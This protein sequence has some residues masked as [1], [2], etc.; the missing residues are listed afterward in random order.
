MIV[1]YYCTLTSRIEE[2]NEDVDGS[3]VDEGMEGYTGSYIKFTHGSI[4][5]V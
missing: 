3:E 5:Y 2:Y 1:A 4:E